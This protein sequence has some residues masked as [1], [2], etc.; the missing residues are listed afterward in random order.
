MPSVWTVYRYYTVP[1]INEGITVSTPNM[2]LLSNLSSP[3][4]ESRATWRKTHQ[5]IEE[6]PYRKAQEEDSRHNSKD[7]R[8]K[9]LPTTPLP[10]ALRTIPPS[11]TT[12]MSPKSPGARSFR[13]MNLPIMFHVSSNP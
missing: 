13:S 8:M 3:Q 11:P 1:E 5:D 6:I 12:P 10:L 7:S 9:A 2:K 4:T